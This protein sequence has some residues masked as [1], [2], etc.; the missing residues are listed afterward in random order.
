MSG[1]VANAY[2]AS[3]T[4]MLDAGNFAET[5]VEAVGELS[6][7]EQ[8]G[9]SLA[10]FDSNRSFDATLDAA[11]AIYHWRNILDAAYP[12]RPGGFLLVT[13]CS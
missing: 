12:V 13:S 9:K 6:S 8:R 4:W 10:D 2:G 7:L 11:G 3:R 5:T 1:A